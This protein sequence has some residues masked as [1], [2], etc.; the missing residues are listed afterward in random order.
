MEIWK[1][2]IGHPQPTEAP[3][4]AQPQKAPA[5][6][7][8]APVQVA[9]SYK[10]DT[11]RS[12]GQIAG[13]SAR[14]PVVPAP[15]TAVA[16]APTEAVIIIDDLPPVPPQPASASLPHG[17]VAHELPKVPNRAGSN[18][19]DASTT[20]IQAPNSSAAGDPLKRKRIESQTNSPVRE[21]P[22]AVVAPATAP[23]GA[24]VPDLKKR[25]VEPVPIPEP[26][27]TNSASDRPSLQPANSQESVMMDV[28]DDDEDGDGVGFSSGP[29]S[30]IVPPVSSANAK[31]NF[32]IQERPHSALKYQI[33]ERPLVSVEV[34]NRSPS[35]AARLE[36]EA[37]VRRALE[38]DQ[39]AQAAKAKIAKSTFTV[40]PPNAGAVR[41]PMASEELR[42]QREEGVRK[43]LERDEEERKRRALLQATAAKQPEPVPS[44]TPFTS[45]NIAFAPLTSDDQLRQNAQPQVVAQPIAKP[46]TGVSQNSYQGSA[47]HASDRQAETRLSTPAQQKEQDA[48]TEQTK[49]RLLAAQAIKRAKEE[50]LARAQAAA[51]RLQEDQ[52]AQAERIARVERARKEDALRAQAQQEAE[53]RSRKEAQLRKEQEEENA[54]AAAALVISRR[55][56]EE[57]RLKREEQLKQERAERLRLERERQRHQAEEAQQIEADR[58]KRVE[59]ER[60][61]E[62]R[63][64]EEQARVQEAERVR[65]QDQARLV[66]QEKARVES[67]RKEAERQAAERQAR[68][69]ESLRELARLQE[70][71]R[72]AQEQ[73]RQQ[74]ERKTLEAAQK[75]EKE[76][77]L[78]EIVAQH[79]AAEEERKR[80]E[81]AKL[82]E[83]ARQEAA[84]VQ[85][86]KIRQ[87]QILE[88]ARVKALEDAAKAAEAEKARLEAEEAERIKRQEVEEVERRLKA[89]AAKKE[90][91]DA[92][93]AKQEA[94]QAKQKAEMDRRTQAVLQ[95]RA[96]L[97]KQK[98]D[99]E[100][101]A[102][103][104]ANEAK[105]RAQEQARL[106]AEAVRKLREAAEEQQ[107][108]EAAKLRMEAEKKPIIQPTSAGPFNND[109]TDQFIRAALGSH[110][111]SVE[112]EKLRQK[113]M[114]GKQGKTTSKPNSPAASPPR[115][116]AE[117]RGRVQQLRG[118]ASG[119]VSRSNSPRLLTPGDL[120][121]GE[122]EERQQASKKLGVQ[123]SRAATPLAEASHS[124]GLVAEPMVK[125]ERVSNPNSPVFPPV[126][127]DAEQNEYAMVP[128]GQT[129]AQPPPAPA[130]AAFQTNAYYGAMTAPY[131]PMY[132]PAPAYPPADSPLTLTPAM[133]Q[134]LMEGMPP[135]QQQA[136]MA[137][138]QAEFWQ[139]GQQRLKQQWEQFSVPL[140]AAHAA[141]PQ[142]Q[143]TD[144]A[145][146][147]PPPFHA[148]FERPM[149][150]QH[151]QQQPTGPAPPPAPVPYPAVPSFAGGVHPTNPSPLHASGPGQ[152]G[153]G[154]EAAAINRSRLDAM[155]NT[156]FASFSSPSSPSSMP[157]PPQHKNKQQQQQFV[158]PPRR[159]A[160]DLMDI[161]PSMA[162]LATFRPV[163]PIAS[164]KVAPSSS[165]PPV[166]VNGAPP[167]NVTA[168]PVHHQQLPVETSI[169]S[170][171]KARV[172][173]EMQERMAQFAPQQR[174][175]QGR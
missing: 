74:E 137:K 166:P 52:V 77:E 68:D 61:A 23:A 122:I 134:R 154:V 98:L 167:A 164:P 8:K 95:E 142:F 48:E 123:I 173:K 116:S 11:S 66:E 124:S 107:K 22:A 14:K 15:K 12:N 158:S 130:A 169:A 44:T 85:A 125:D 30:V 148:N 132:Q 39:Q 117:D 155:A 160:P 174:P 32:H 126:A 129:H 64:Q 111:H 76:R 156:S 151:H 49:N 80:L 150:Q 145:M 121:D 101:Q 70:R 71:Q 41:E 103:E 7:K 105:R 58:I 3:A 40:V 127:L 108:V 5:P 16:Q 17:S 118:L 115:A 100:R 72:Q 153:S 26:T 112:A 131:V 149:P 91:D 92:E 157:H 53:I 78:H 96:A 28:T 109:A 152:A 99:A 75:R 24:A 54:R 20:A 35:E 120:E 89:A 147:Q 113:L 9:G 97:A 47:L 84:R 10:P 165:R 163:A 38:R 2:L 172:F 168:H 162:D 133:T 73:E 60:Q 57:I 27:R 45:N 102:Q 46:S 119:N 62:Q 161:S 81:K 139:A 104:K 18:V 25:R 42:V 93:R 50:G 34:V 63:R 128:F 86:E 82:A 88:R 51:T 43:A 170:E 171:D 37:G 144:F 114:Q 143:P 21:V 13:G 1:T 94:E 29:I 136:F 31:A 69:A 65:L 33:H 138:L 159:Q 87:E 106:D 55:N 59:E 67:L 56:A 6:A 146:P 175:E 83:A 90:R 36:R 135:E 19:Q 110:N 4:E 140:A 79:Q 141:P